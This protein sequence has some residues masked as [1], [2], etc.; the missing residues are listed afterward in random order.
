M[1]CQISHFMFWWLVWFVD[2][3]QFFLQLSGTTT[4][5]S[6]LHLF[7]T[8]NICGIGLFAYSCCFWFKFSPQTWVNQW[9]NFSHGKCSMWWLELKLC[10]LLN[11]HSFQSMVIILVSTC[12]ICYVVSHNC[13]CPWPAEDSTHGLNH[14]SNWCGG[15]DTGYIVTFSASVLPLFALVLPSPC[16]RLSSEHGVLNKQCHTHKV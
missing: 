4:Y 13:H 8:I 16:R 9:G 12:H 11:F 7:S 5:H 10:H 1:C 15:S 6:I 14:D 3:T 2:W